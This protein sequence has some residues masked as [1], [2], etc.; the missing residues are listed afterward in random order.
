MR[1][2][3]D[4]FDGA[5]PTSLQRSLA[6]VGPNS[7]PVTPDDLSGFPAPLIVRGHRPRSA[8]KAGASRPF[9]SAPAP[10]QY[11]AMTGP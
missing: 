5:R 2:L 9:L 4:G 10:P 11:L 6:G 8:K 3:T 7:T 1:A